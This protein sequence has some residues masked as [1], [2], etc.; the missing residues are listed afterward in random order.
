MA[1][2]LVRHAGKATDAESVDREYLACVRLAG[3]RVVVEVRPRG[4]D[5]QYVPAGAAE[6][7]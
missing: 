6:H 7:A 1:L 5:E 2:A 3:Q 4:G